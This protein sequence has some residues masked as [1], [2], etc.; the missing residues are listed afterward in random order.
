MSE[1]RIAG[2]TVVVVAIATITALIFRTWLQ[3]T[4]IRAGTD[5][6]LAADLSYLLVPP[7]MAL[8]LAPLWR[9]ERRFIIEQLQLVDLSR[10]F[11]LQALLVG[12]L[13]RLIW[14]SQLVA[15]VAF[16]VYSASTSDVPV[17]PVF[18][19]RCASPEGLGLGFL[20]TVLLTPTIEELVN[21]GYFLSFL[22]PRGPLIAIL[23]SA[24]V[25]AVLHKSTFWPFAFLAGIVFGYL[26]WSTRSL[27]SGL[28]AHV[29]FNA[30]T[31]LDWRCLSVQ[32]NPG[33]DAVPAMTPGV[34]AITMLIASA[35][36]LAVV[37]LKMATV[38]SPPVR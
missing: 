4:L 33:A 17:G 25:F 19:F 22:R 5:T 27:W 35:V 31:L 1:Q 12:V 20:V 34:T 38:R 16:G 15:G 9:T 29:T 36:A 2:K 28:I 18:G 30:L 6:R 26:Y 24:A 37:L 7:I 32:W 10:R 13:L 11:L 3:V 8:L 23:V 14:W 21:R